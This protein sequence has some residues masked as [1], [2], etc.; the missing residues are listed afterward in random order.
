M[1]E[2]VL[3]CWLSEVLWRPSYELYIVIK[4]H[5]I[6]RKRGGFPKTGH[7]KMVLEGKRCWV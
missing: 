3:F 5:K 1:R 4:N 2:L 7:E 6:N